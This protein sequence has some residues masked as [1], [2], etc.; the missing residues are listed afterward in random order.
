[1][2]MDEEPDSTGNEWLVLTVAVPT[3]IGALLFSYVL[4]ST[5]VCG[6]RD[7]CNPTSD[8][9]I[10]FGTIGLSLLVLPGLMAILRRL[11]PPR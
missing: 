2:S 3:V 11:G 1:M 6:S 10:I 5:L 8:S 4:F 7:G 9:G